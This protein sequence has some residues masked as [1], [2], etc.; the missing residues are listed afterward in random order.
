[1]RFTMLKL[2]LKP[3]FTMIELIFVIIILGIVSSIGAEIIANVYTGYVLQRAQH[4]AS[5]KTELAAIQIAN[6]LAYAIPGTVLRKDTLSDANPVSITEPG[7]N[8]SILQWVGADVDSFNAINSA[9]AVGR[10]P[11][12]SGFCDIDASTTT[13]ISTPGSNL[14]LAKKIRINLNLTSASPRV[15]FPSKS[16]L[17][18]APVS[19]TLSGNTITL[20]TATT[21]TAV[22]VEHYK[23]AFSSYALEAKTNG[24]LVLH[25]NFAPSFNANATNGSNKLLLKNVSVFRFKGEGRTIRFKICVDE[26]IGETTPI[27][28]CKEKAVF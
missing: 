27:T 16:G 26:D 23:L 19:G 6:R 13:S 14:I 22:V 7:A 1:M 12:W 20:T 24:D 8:E 21:P 18:S 5:I 15:Y 9:T 28:I 10:R 11:G 4:R 17:V 2:T 25:Y 3:A